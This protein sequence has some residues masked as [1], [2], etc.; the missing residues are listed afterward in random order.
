MRDADN[1]IRIYT[2]D[3][4]TDYR[5]YSLWYDH[6]YRNAMNWQMCGYNQPPHVSFALSEFEDMAVPPAPMTMTGRTEV[7]NNGT[8]DT[9]L[10]G[11]HVIVCETNDMTLSAADGASPAILTVN[12]PTWVEGHNNNNKITTKSYTHTISAGSIGGNMRLIKQGDGKLVMPDGTHSYTGKTEVWAGTFA[13]NGELSSSPIWLNRFGVLETSKLN[14]P[15]GIDM[16]YAS[17]LRLGDN[18]TAGE[19]TTGDMTLGFGSIVE[20]DAFADGSIDKINASKLTIEKK[21]WVN[22]PEYLQPIIK[23]T[24]HTDDT[25]TPLPTGKYLIGEIGEIEGNI[26]DI[27]LLGLEEMKKVLVYEDGKL[28]ADLSA[29]QPGVKTWIGGENSMWDLDHSLAFKNE[30]SGN[31]DVF[32]PGD[33]VVFDDSATSTDVMINGRLKP[34]SVTFN[35]NE[36]DYTLSGDGQIV[37]DAKLVKEGEGSLTISNINSYTGGTYINGGKLIAGVFANKIGNDLGALSNVDAPIYINNDATLAVNASGTLGQRITMQ[38]GNAALEVPDGLT[39]T[40]STGISA[41]GLGQKLYKRGKGTLNLAGGNSMSRLVIEEGTVNA[42]EVNDVISLP[43]MVEFVRGALWDPES[44]YTYSKNPTNYHVESGNSGSLYLDSRCSYS[45]KLTGAGTLSV[46]AA[47]VRCDLTGNWSEFEGELIAGYHKRGAYDPDFKWDNDLGMP[48]ATLSISSGVTFN[49]QDRNMKLGCLKG[50]GT[51]HGTGTLTVGNDEKNI[52]FSG[53]FS[54][55]PKVVKIGK[56]DMILSKLISE[57]NGLTAKEGTIS[58]SASKSPYNTEYLKAPLTLEGDAMLRGRGTVGNITVNEGGVLE[59]G[60]YSDKNTQ[61]Y[62]PIYSTGNVTVNE[63]ATLSLYLRAAGKNN[64]CSYLDVKGNLTVNGNVI[65]TMNPD[66]VPIAGDQF[67]LWIT[68]NFSGNPNIELPELPEGLAWDFTGLS[69]TT[70]ILKVT[71]GSCVSQISAN[72]L[73]SCKVFDA[74]GICIGTLETTKGN[75]A[76]A[77]KNEFNLR[78]GIYILVLSAEDL[79]E[80]LKLQF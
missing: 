70:G 76:E 3:I 49:A 8:I 40:T 61:H 13:L 55:K 11:K 78:S 53:A 39:L 54:G 68:D 38:D 60:S 50:S 34:S 37:G 67:R 26:A 48:K 4:P 22:G 45:G 19:L 17:V 35:N 18:D 43:T 79:T 27:I 63:G 52:S 6:Q 10:N 73:V 58:L 59:P 15:A 66:Y 80:T 72:T 25:S 32:V 75:A 30:E 44:M 24:A 74:L 69:D 20:L 29:Y 14:A 47:G 7:A 41:G 62:G 51:Y 42:S 36:K 16:N 65:V 33:E 23:F 2:T 1:N 64:D 46:Y 56:C 9:S 31:E 21:D 5:I 57:I 12:T 28:Y 77:V 71:D